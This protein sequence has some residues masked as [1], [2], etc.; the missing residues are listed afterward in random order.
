MTLAAC[1]L[2]DGGIMIVDDVVMYPEESERYPWAGVPS[3]VFP[4][5][6]AQARFAPFLW[7]H[8]KVYLTTVTHHERLLAAVSE[9]SAV[10]CAHTLADI[11]VSRNAIGPHLVCINMKRALPQEDLL[12]AMLSSQ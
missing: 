6:L 1:L 5:V 10:K 2:V 8:N 9:H 3:A 12:Q 4:W 11:H 7:A